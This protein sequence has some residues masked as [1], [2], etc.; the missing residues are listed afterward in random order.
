MLALSAAPST[1]RAFLLGSIAEAQA[2]AGNLQKVLQIAE[3]IP[4]D[5]ASRVSAFR[6]LASA[7]ARVGLMTEARETFSQARQLAGSLDDLSRAEALKSIA[8]AQADAGMTVEAT[9]MFEA[10]LGLAKALEISARLPCI[11]FPSAEFRRDGLFKTLA[12]REARAGV[13][14]DSL[15]TARLIKYQPH[16]RAGVLRMIAELQAER[17]Q[18]VEAG[19]IFKEAVEAAHESQTPPEFWPSC[20]GLRPRGASPEL[21]AETLLDIAKAQART[22]LMEDAAVTLEAA[23]QIVPMIRDGAL[24]SADASTARVLTQIAEV[25]NEMGFGPQSAVT[26]ERAVQAASEVREAR[27]HIMVLALLGRAQYKAGRVSEAMRSF[28]GALALARG[29][30]N[31]PERANG[32][33]TV[34]DAELDLGLAETDRLMLDAIE[35]TRSNPDQSKRVLSLVRIASARERAGQRQGAVDSYR[36]ALE[37][38]DTIPNWTARANSLF[39]VIRQFPGRS[40]VTRLLAESAPQAIQIT[41]S[42]DNALRRAEALVV[43]AGALPN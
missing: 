3:A 21:Y 9:D 20:P 43:I 37:A 2:T 26:F 29:L 31:Y 33:L 40:P 4:S 17:G 8:Q 11:V 25:Q 12:E 19:L 6:A 13:I 35:A 30:D 18:K 36:E 22:S 42:I 27:L 15:Q 39:L 32:L 7:Q 34:L 5:Q 23:L 41:E 14:S 38:V 28:D 1:N 16:L 24:W 10:A